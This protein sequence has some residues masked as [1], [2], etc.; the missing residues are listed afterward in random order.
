MM[1]TLRDENIFF[2]ALCAQF[3]KG[4]FRELASFALERHLADVF[5]NFVGSLLEHGSVWWI[6]LVQTSS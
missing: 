6:L 3:C 2:V 5:S 1:L 4:I